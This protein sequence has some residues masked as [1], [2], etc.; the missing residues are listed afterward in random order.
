MTQQNTEENKRKVLQYWQEGWNKKNLEVLNDI[1]ESD[2][3]AVDIPPWRK[4]GLK[5]LKDFIQDNFRMFPDV[6]NTIEDLIAENDKVVSRVTAKAT[7]KGDLVGP[8]GL[9]KAT[10]KQISWKGVF[11]FEFKNGKV[12]RTWSLVDNMDLMKQLG[13][14]PSDES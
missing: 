2:Y 12:V 11:I 6:H 8:V 7:H 1:F 13:A 9:V 10:N 4:P 5:G 14:L 3:I